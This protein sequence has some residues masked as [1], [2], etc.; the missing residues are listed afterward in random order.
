MSTEAHRTRQFPSRTDTVGSAL[1]RS[2]KFCSKATMG[3][4]ANQGKQGKL[5]IK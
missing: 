1:G 3:K 5:P 2:V 4:P